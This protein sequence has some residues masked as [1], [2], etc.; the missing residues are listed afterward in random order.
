MPER[1]AEAQWTGDLLHGSGS[2]KLGSGSYE[3]AYSFGSRMQAAAG[4]NPEELIGAALAGCFSMALSAG[5]GKAGATP[6]RIH[7]SAHVH[8]DKIGEGFK[9]SRISLR[10]TA[11]VAGIDEPAFRREAEAA[12]EKCPVS[13]ALAGVTIELDAHLEK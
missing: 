13:Q 8:F 2:M 1:T 7:T 5:L 11:K 6:E 10:T 12:K 9:I 4:T 3:G